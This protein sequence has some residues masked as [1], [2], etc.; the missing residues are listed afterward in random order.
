MAAN[1]VPPLREE[2]SPLVRDRML[3]LEHDKP[4]AFRTLDR[5]RTVVII[6]FAPVEYHG[7]HL[8]FSTD[9]IL[10]KAFSVASA[11]SFLSANPEWNVILYPVIPM[12]ADCVPHP[13]SAAVHYRVLVRAAQSLAQHFIRHGFF[14]IVLQ[15]GHGGVN[16]DRALERASRRLNRRYRTRHVRVIAPLGRVMFRLW[17]EG[18][19][20][21][22]NPLLQKTISADEERDFVYE[23]HGGWW[24][25]AMVL[26]YHPERM[27]E[28]YRG[29]PDY[30]PKIKPV[31]RVLL[32]L[33]QRIVPSRQRRLIEES[34]DLLL[35]GLSWFWGDTH[36]GYLGFPSRAHPEMGRAVAQVAGQDF[37]RL[38]QRI[39]VEGVDV[40]EAESVYALLDLLRWYG[41]GA[42][43]TLLVMLA[44][45]IIL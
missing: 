44:L 4:E 11:E 38:F 15:S 32:G 41:L 26:A 9:L 13:G 21:R 17:A 34:K 18:F 20:D 35:V 23:L 14:N 29:T 3:V 33:V 30:V 39:F 37:A 27:D 8:T 12:G 5:K 7:D 28:A 24:E 22:I 40:R 2:I 45:F 6:P 31:F 42:L 43:I 19:R 16:H 25:T 36:D 1:E 10:A